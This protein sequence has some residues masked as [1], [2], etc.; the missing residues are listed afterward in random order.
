MRDVRR[1]LPPLLGLAG[2][3]AW[4]YCVVAVV[5][6]GRLP[7]GA[8]DFLIGVERWSARVN[9]YLLLQVDAYPPFSLR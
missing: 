4:L 3:L 7:R 2:I 1:C 8:F 9:A 5:A 6:T